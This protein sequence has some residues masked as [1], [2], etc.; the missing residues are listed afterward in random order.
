MC[1]LCN[2]LE[3]LLS[4]GK[5]AAIAKLH[6]VLV[7]EPIPPFKENIVSMFS[8]VDQSIKL[9]LASPLL[10]KAG[11]KVCKK[12]KADN[13]LLKQHLKILK[14]RDENLYN[15]VSYWLGRV[16]WIK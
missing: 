14:I 5:I 8:D 16:K 7:G 10:P 12:W 15:L 6:R 9:I 13:N 2:N 3:N 11:Y 1:A 4:Y